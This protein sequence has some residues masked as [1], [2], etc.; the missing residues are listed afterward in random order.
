M[1]KGRD[2]KNES[3]GG[4]SWT[5]CQRSGGQVPRGANQLAALSTS[6]NLTPVYPPTQVAIAVLCLL[7]I[8]SLFGL[9]KNGVQRSLKKH[10]ALLPP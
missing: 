2:G 8:V 3:R 6:H 5:L 4:Q 9:S 10:F 7:S 1:E